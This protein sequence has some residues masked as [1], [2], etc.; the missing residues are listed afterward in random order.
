MFKED[1]LKKRAREILGISEGAPIKEIQKARR[2]KAKCYHPDINL[3][4]KSLTKKMQLINE[5]YLQL[6]KPDARTTSLLE[7]KELVEEV[8]GEVSEIDAPSYDEWHREQF[9]GKGSIWPDGK[10]KKV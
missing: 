6:T 3:D 2:A 10:K 1:E 4:D 9:Y 8:I 5:A 7:D